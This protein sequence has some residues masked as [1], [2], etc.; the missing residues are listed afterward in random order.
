MNRALVLWWLGVCACVLAIW[1]FFGNLSALL[2]DQNAPAWVQ[3]IGSILAIVVAVAVP[4]FQHER[5]Q[6]RQRQQEQLEHTRVVSLILDCAEE[7]K[8]E[9][10]EAGS[11]NHRVKQAGLNGIDDALLRA[12]VIRV[13]VLQDQLNSFIPSQMPS[14]QAFRLLKR[15][16]KRVDRLI[17]DVHEAGPFRPGDPTV[18]RDIHFESHYGN[19]TQL[20][21]EI[22]FELERIVDPRA[23]PPWA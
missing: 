14:P 20:V 10:H 2:Q 11:T 23:I 9:V 3:A 22:K 1:L 13:T 7:L 19:A 6:A 4:A 15:L 5:D 8:S 18:K 21:D 12:M 17:E 16:Q